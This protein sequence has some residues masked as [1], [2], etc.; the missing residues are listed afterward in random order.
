MPLRTSRNG[1]A[2]GI[3][4]TH[5]RAFAAQGV[6]RIDKVTH[7]P[8]KLIT[9][10]AV[11]T[12]GSYRVAI[13]ARLGRGNGSPVIDAWGEVGSLATAGRWANA[14]AAPLRRQQDEGQRDQNV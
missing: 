9:P 8:P 10:I 13:A 5:S 3:D 6:D 2:A 14:L 1:I 7:R 11:A 4:L 12:T